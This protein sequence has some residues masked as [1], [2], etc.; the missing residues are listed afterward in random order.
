MAS[1]IITD[2]VSRKLYDDAKRRQS[3]KL[4]RIERSQQRYRSVTVQANSKSIK[5]LTKRFL[6]DFDLAMS[7]QGLDVG[8]INYFNASQILKDMG[9]IAAKNQTLESNEERILFI[10]MCRVLRGDDTDSVHSNNIKLFLGAIEGFRFK[11]TQGKT[12]EFLDKISPNRNTL[13]GSKKSLNNTNSATRRKKSAMPIPIEPTFDKN[14]K[15]DL[16]QSEIRSIQ[17]YYFI[18]ARNRSDFLSIKNHQKLNNQ[19]LEASKVTHKPNIDKYSRKIIQDLHEKLSDN[20]IPHYEFLLFK[21]REYERKVNES[22]TH[23][24]HRKYDK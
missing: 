4:E 13:S 21:G 18:F 11:N 2:Q 10:D 24:E 22:R 23:D 12:L 16:S 6:T 7:K 17:N 14:G 5:Y 1:C 9:F 8:M 15:I 3:Q 19:V 20:Q